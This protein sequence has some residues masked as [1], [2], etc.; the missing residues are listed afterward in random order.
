MVSCI[1]IASKAAEPWAKEQ[2]Y[3]AGDVVQSPTDVNI[4]LVCKQGPFSDFCSISPNSHGGD[5]GWID[6]KLYNIDIES[7]V[8][9]CHESGHFVKDDFYCAKDS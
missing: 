3:K 1:S 6:E 9:E 5:T 7:E 2:K 4:T 8:V